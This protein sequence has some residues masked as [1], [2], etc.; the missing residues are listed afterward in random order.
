[1]IGVNG[2]DRFVSRLKK[3]ES[4]FS[5]GWFREEEWSLIRL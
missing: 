1:M 2:I 5:V 4:L 3:K